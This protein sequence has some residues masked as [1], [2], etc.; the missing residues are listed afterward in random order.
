[1]Y[2]GFIVVLLGCSFALVQY[3]PFLHSFLLKWYCICRVIICRRNVIFF[4]KL[5]WMHF[6]LWCGIWWFGWEISLTGSFIS[7][8]GS[9]VAKLWSFRRYGLAGSSMSLGAGFKHH[10]ISSSFSLFPACESKCE[11]VCCLSHH[12]C[13]L[14]STMMASH[15]PEASWRPQML[16]DDVLRFLGLWKVVVLLK[17]LLKF[18][19]F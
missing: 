4:L 10:T 19:F 6:T 1:M 12:C 5:D 9:Q 15:P 13:C 18:F 14:P 8:H 17:R 3:F 7:P 11:L 16:S 2:T